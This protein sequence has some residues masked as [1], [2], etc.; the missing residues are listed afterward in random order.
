[1]IRIS[2]ATFGRNLIEL[3]YP[4]VEAI[5][6]ILPIVDEFVVNVGKSDDE[7]LNLIQS[8]KDPKVRIIESVWD[9]NL[10]KDGLIFSQQANIAFAACKGDWIFHLNADEVIH[11]KDLPA[12]VNSVKVNHDRKKILGLMFRYYHFDGDYWSIN[13]WRYRKEIRLVRNDGRV[14]P[15][16]DMSGF[17]STEDGIYLKGG[18][19]D[20]WAF[21]RAYVYHYGW[22]RKSPKIMQE[23]N[24]RLEHYYHDDEYVKNKYEDLDEFDYSYYEI[25]KEF[26]GTHPKTMLER[27]EN[28]KRLR[29][30][31]N[32]W[33]NWR[34][35]KEVLAHGF[36]G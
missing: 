15:C 1:M 3:D 20:R 23:R 16:G 10:R 17:E 12:I 33:L 4:V 32:R 31:K 26:R 36:K 27:I 22:V 9:D 5:T 29:P 25:L 35:Y 14:R 11:E 7:T 19:K 2:G 6:S 8:I 18:P 21:S 13:P 34:F 28:S 24:K 30:R